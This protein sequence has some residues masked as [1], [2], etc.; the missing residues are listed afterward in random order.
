[1]HSANTL[2]LVLSSYAA[3]CQRADASMNATR[4]QIEAPLIA[5]REALRHAKATAL[6]ELASTYESAYLAAHRTYENEYRRAGINQGLAVTR[7]LAGIDQRKLE[8]DV[9]RAARVSHAQARY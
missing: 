9:E 2:T 4:E 1:M 5:A 7:A 8:I 6:K 3:A